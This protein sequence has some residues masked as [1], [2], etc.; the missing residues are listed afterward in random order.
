MQNFKPLIAKIT[1]VTISLE[2]LTLDK[3]N[4]K[5]NHFFLLAGAG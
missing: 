2:F 5:S 4:A 3:P 1:V